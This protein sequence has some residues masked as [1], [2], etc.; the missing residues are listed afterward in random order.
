MRFVAR[1]L[2][3]QLLSA[4]RGFGAVVLTGPRRAGKT[5]LLRHLLPGADYVQ[6]EDPDILSRVRVD[7]RGFLEERRTPVILDEIQNAPELF[8]YVRTILDRSPRRT[9]RWFLT[10]SQ[11]SALMRGVTES[12]AGRAA[13]F[14][15]F[16]LSLS[17]SPKVGLLAGGFPEVLARPAHRGTWFSSYVQSYLERDVRTVTNVR[18][19]GTFRRFLGLVASRHGQVLNRSDLAAPLGVTI[20]TIG[21]W[22]SIL[23]VTGQILLVPPYF[24]NYGKRLIKSPKVYLVDSGLACHL[25]GIRS[26]AELARSPFRG[27]LFEGFVAA[28]IVKA[29]QNAGGRR[30]IY[31]FRDR[32]GFEVD[33][34]VPRGSET[35]L[36]EVKASRTVFP[37]DAKGIATLRSGRKGPRL[38]RGIVVHEDS[39]HRSATAVVAEGIRA[40]PLGDFVAELNRQ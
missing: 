20:P 39:R 12:L 21:E 10:G 1:R 14:Q 24:E 18:D 6:L 31:F 34:V 9:G 5:T 35:W 40:L 30:D 23:E 27:A 37:H 29:Q 28:E 8:N 33:F 13:I 15:L 2:G 26:R 32:P 22:L 38:A 4:A 36:V 17:E 16:P 7:P 11:E 19:L 25:L 3:S